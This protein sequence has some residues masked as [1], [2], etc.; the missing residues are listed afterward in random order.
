MVACFAIAGV[1]PAHSISVRQTTNL[2]RDD[3]SVVDW[4]VERANPPALKSPGVI[5]VRP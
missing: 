4:M 2:F 1:A 5:P 3:L